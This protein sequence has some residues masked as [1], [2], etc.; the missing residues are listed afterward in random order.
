MRAHK[1]LL[2][3]LGIPFM[4]SAQ[5]DISKDILRLPLINLTAGFHIPG[6]DLA[7]RFGSSSTLG[8]SFHLKNE[9][10]TYWGIDVAAL[11]GSN[12]KED[13]I[14]DIITADSLDIIDVN[15]H[16]ASIR[17]WE[18]GA[19]SQLVLGK[20]I[21]VLGPNKNSGLFIQGG[22]G[23]IYHKI[24]IEDIGNQSP[25]LNSELLKG[26]DRLCMGF[27]T[28]QFVGY[29]YFSNNH[30]IN[31]FVG[32]EFIQAFT[33]D[34]RQYD[35]NA[36]MAYEDKRVDLL[37]GLKFGWTFPLYEKSDNKYYYY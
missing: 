20:I 18:R 37:S 28:S 1:L 8:A 15:G 17:F 12:V 29:R 4:L 10:N 3:L 14:L 13:N 30:K 7:D 9:N 25:Q 6:G 32:M 35:Y 11:A 22:L 2:L 23:Y 36:Q 27:T 16:T 26:Y 5:E 19:Q 33:Q 21:P 31:F 24:R 34:V